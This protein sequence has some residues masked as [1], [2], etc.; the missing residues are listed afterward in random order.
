LPAL[1]DGHASVLNSA[2]ALGGACARDRRYPRDRRQPRARALNGDCALDSDR[3]LGGDRAL[4]GARARLQSTTRPQSM[5]HLRA[6]R[7]SQSAN[8]NRNVILAHRGGF[9]CMTHRFNVDKRLQAGRTFTAYFYLYVIDY[10]TH[11]YGISAIE[12]PCAEVP[13]PE[14]MPQL[15]QLKN[16]PLELLTQS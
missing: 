14:R 10:F 6:R 7:R 15:R 16:I 9:E 12:I 13:E 4:D 8:G 2:R 3:A 5:V 11:E 1:D